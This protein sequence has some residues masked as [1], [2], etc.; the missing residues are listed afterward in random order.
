L[1]SRK[2]THGKKEIFRARNRT[3]KAGAGATTRWS[4]TGRYLRKKGRQWMK[5]GLKRRKAGVWGAALSQQKKMTNGLESRGKGGK[6]ISRGTGLTGRWC[7]GGGGGTMAK[8]KN[9]CAQ[10]GKNGIGGI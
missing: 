7:A 10:K 3:G 6:K 4:W 5:G 1:L 9:D 2:N 8:G